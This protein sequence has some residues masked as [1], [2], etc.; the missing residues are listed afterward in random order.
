MELIKH[1]NAQ[2]IEP[3]VERSREVSVGWGKCSDVGTLYRNPW[4][5]RV[6]GCNSVSGCSCER[7]VAAEC[8]TVSPSRASASRASSRTGTSPRRT[9]S[10]GD[11]ALASPTIPTCAPRDR[12]Q[13]TAMANLT[14]N[15]SDADAL[16][17][18]LH[19]PGFTHLRMRRCGAVLTIESW[20]WRSVPVRTPPARQPGAPAARNGDP[21]GQVRTHAR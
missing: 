14:E 7:C 1:A 16:Q 8:S 15:A 17:S 9:R 12:R 5:R 2:P 3:L 6:S 13:A 4:E 21:R 19:E 18:F 10:A 11:S 20:R